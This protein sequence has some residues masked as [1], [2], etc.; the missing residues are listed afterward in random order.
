M[1]VSVRA[2]RPNPRRGQ[3]E[4]I[5]RGTDRGE[6]A[7]KMNQSNIDQMADI[8]RAVAKPDEVERLKYHLEK[9]TGILCGDRANVYA[10]SGYA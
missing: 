9:G 10:E 4:S 3:T 1:R 7:S 8:I 5:P 2:P 6:G